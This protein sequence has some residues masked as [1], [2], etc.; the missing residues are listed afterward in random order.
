MHCAD[1]VQMQQR[2]SASSGTK[3]LRAALAGR[4]TRS[5]ARFGF[6]DVCRTGA[7]KTIRNSVIDEPM[8]ALPKIDVVNRR[9][10]DSLCLPRL[11]HEHSQ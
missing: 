3:L 10:L 11:E 6:I 7:R 2:L 5:V 1:C 9:E 4:L 8:P